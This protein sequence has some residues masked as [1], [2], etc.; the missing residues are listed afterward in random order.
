MRYI[1]IASAISVVGGLVFLLICLI[2]AVR[3]LDDG[4]SESWMKVIRERFTRL[5]W[6]GIVGLIVSGVYNWVLG[7][8]T[9]KAIG[10]IGNAIIGFK[11]LL[12]MI[13]FTVV[14]AGSMGLLKP[15]V[16]HMVNIHIAALVIL[17]A[18]ILR[19]MRL[20]YLQSLVEGW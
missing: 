11:V 5:L 16:C 10:P 3:L 6:I 9:Y 7:A 19:H 2:P 17:L 1:H 20:E 13:M 4:F 18:V 14:W 12:A 15:K 8:S